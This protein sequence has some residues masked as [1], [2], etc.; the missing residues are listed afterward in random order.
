MVAATIV[1]VIFAWTGLR[2]GRREGAIVFACYAAYPAT[3]WLRSG[4]A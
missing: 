2:I 1:I 3:P 4:S